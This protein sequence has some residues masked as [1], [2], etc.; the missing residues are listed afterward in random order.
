MG[1]HPAQLSGHL[2]L[3]APHVFKTEVLYPLIVSWFVLYPLIVSWFTF[4]RIKFRLILNS[5]VP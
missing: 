2:L 4:L 1:S 3:C 5:A